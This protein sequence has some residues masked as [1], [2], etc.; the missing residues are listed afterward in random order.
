MSLPMGSGAGGSATPLAPGNVP[1]KL[2][3]VWFSS[4]TKIT[5]S[6]GVVGDAVA[7]RVVCADAAG[8]EPARNGG[9]AQL[10][11]APAP[12]ALSASRRLILPGRRSSA[13]PPGPSLIVSTLL[14]PSP[15]G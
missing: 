2:S 5:F 11:T 3:N 6:I 8:A 1:K 12:M 9:R 15:G 4:I 10:A 14:D 13:D 7:R